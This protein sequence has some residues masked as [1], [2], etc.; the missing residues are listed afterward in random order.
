MDVVV[1]LN[2]KC[3]VVITTAQLNSTTPVLSFSAGSD[4][5]RGVSEICHGEDL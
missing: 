1:I 3:L 2:G 4:P 5:A